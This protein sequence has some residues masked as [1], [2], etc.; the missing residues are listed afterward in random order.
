MSIPIVAGRSFGRLGSQR[1]GDAIVSVSTARYF[2]RD[3]TGAAALGKRFRPV[4]NGHVYTVIG[5]AGDVRDTTLSAPSSQVVYFPETLEAVGPSRTKRTL[6]LVVRLADAQMSVRG[7]VQQALHDLDPTLPLFDVKP[8]SAVMSEA[9]A[10]LSFTTLIL[11]SAAA[12]TLILGAVGLYGVLAY[13]VT[14]RQRELGIRL[15]LGASPRSVAAALTRDGLALVLAGLAVGLPIFAAAARFL[16]GFLFG[17]TA[18]DPLTLSGATA[19][20]LLTAMLA[21]WLP[22]RRAARVDPAGALRAE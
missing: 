13:I 8:M 15:A 14:L 9:T 17:V 3:P 22:A 21:S 20:L 1:E 6:A 10:Q 7:G 11:G 16:R 2:W 4:P 12:M 18:G 19:V 5:V